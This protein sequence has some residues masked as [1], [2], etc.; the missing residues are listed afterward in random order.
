MED[1]DKAE[2]P[3]EQS[4]VLVARDYANIAHLEN[5]SIIEH[6]LSASRN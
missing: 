6:I 5:P 4:Y 3:I 2:S 1:N